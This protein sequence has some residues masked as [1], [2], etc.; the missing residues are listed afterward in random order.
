MNEFKVT[1]KNRYMVIPINMNAK[2]KKIKMCEGGKLIYDF[3]AHLDFDTPRYYSYLNVERFKGRTLV[4]TCEPR[5]DIRFTF[6]DAIPTAGMYKEEFRPLVHFTAGI[7]WTNDPNGPTLYDGKY[8]LFFQHNPLD[9]AWGNMTWGHALSDDLI[10][11]HETESAL[12]PDEMGTMFSGSGIE[13]I[14]NVSGLDKGAFILYYTAAGNNSELSKGRMSTQCMAYSTDGGNSFAKYENNP[15]IPHIEGANRDP[16]IVWCEEL[17]CY[18][19]ALYID[20]NE[21]ALFSSDDL[22]HF[23]EQQRIRLPGDAECPDL[24][25]VRTENGSRERKWVFAGASDKYLVGEFNKKK[26]FR[27]IPSQSARSYTYGKRTSYAAQSFS[28]TGDRRIRM[29]WEI[30]HAPESVF[31][32]QMGI[33]VEIS[34]VKLGGEYRLRTLPVK[35]FEC[36]RV[37]S[38]THI[39]SGSAFERPLHKKAYDLSIS[40]PTDS[41]EF[42]ISFFGYRFRIKPSENLF[43]YDDVT[44]PLSYGE[45]GRINIR[46]ISDVLGCEIFI[47]N[48]LIYTVAGSLADYGIRYFTLNSLSERELNNVEVTIHTLKGIR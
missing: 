32:N 23:T 6:V 14:R 28:G 29:A 16:K 42:E 18:L 21:Y 34:L 45:I 48:G 33:P 43:A 46:I 38:E 5:A 31:E 37:G 10:H 36:L 24:Y 13:D 19:L 4:L 3:D 8:H 2:M 44:A 30:L 12:Y 20:G 41:P 47:D 35:E 39:V 11:W 26:G 40:A 1:V 17:D 9:S 25:P 7:G 27:F 15:V 22:I